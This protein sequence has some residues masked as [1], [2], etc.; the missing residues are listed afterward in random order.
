[1][2]A[3]L[4]CDS[5]IDNDDEHLGIV[6]PAIGGAISAVSSLFGG[7]PNPKDPGRLATNA[8]HYSEAIA[9]DASALN[10]LKGMS[11]RFGTV[12]DNNLCSGT[13][14]CNGWATSVAKDDAFKKYNQAV[15]ILSQKP[16]STVTPA[17]G[18]TT[19]MSSLG[20]PVVAGLSTGPLLIAGA[21]GLALFMMTRGGKRRR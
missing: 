3:G 18:A 14:G 11:G 5:C 6:L 7:G 8:Q 20:G 13:S 10:F 21:A 12:R 16:A 4:G 15:A 1:M 17:G 19:T 9:G 2:Y